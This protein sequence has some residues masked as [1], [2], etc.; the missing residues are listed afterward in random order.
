M[1]S[2]PKIPPTILIEIV[3]TGAEIIKNLFKAGKEIGNTKS[4]DTEDCEISDLSQINSIFNDFRLS[5]ESQV[6]NIEKSIKDELYYYLDEVIDMFE[7]HKINASNIKSIKRKIAK[8]KRG[9]DK[10]LIKEISRN[11]SLDNYE[12]R[13]IVKMMPGSKKTD[14]MNEYFK[15]TLDKA[16]INLIE[17]IKEDISM[18]MED[19]EVD[20]DESI[21]IIEDRIRNQL[22]V[23]EIF[24][25]SNIYN[26]EKKNEVIEKNILSILLMES[27]LEMLE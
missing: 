11:I 2:I 7:E 20:M 19:I 12:C 17:T 6:Q 4:K 24:E 3:K 21:E 23:L 8:I 16:I 15:K 25:N 1:I 5:V 10:T 18:F 26:V 22:E 27:A 13:Q 9:V 14:R